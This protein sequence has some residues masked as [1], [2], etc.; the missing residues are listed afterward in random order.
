MTKPEGTA[1]DS[2]PGS[3]RSDSSR[4]HEGGCHCGAVRFRATL[5]PAQGTR[6]NCSIC[7][8]VAQIG[9]I[10]RP[11][12]FEL[13]SDAAALGLYRWR[14]GDGERCFCRHCGVHCFGRGTLEMLGGAFV[15]VN[16]NCLDDVDPAALRPGN[17]D[18]RHDNWQAGTRPEPWPIHAAI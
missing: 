14:T 18:G 12:A 4:S 3:N 17:W 16:V 2:N 15:S 13:L 10:I 1:T 7:T 6:C 8:K 5:D 11:D 9:V